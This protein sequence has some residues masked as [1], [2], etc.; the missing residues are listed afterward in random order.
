M[1]RCLHTTNI[2]FGQRDIPIVVYPEFY[3][4]GGVWNQQEAFTG[5][6]RQEIL[7]TFP[8]FNADQ[9]TNQGYYFG[10]SREAM[11]DAWERAKSILDKF[12]R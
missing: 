8:N 9:I 1:L 3:E 2:I 7:E 4:V 12:Q 10:K 6:T 11:E 5:M